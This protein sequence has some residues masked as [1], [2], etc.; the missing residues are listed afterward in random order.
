MAK[1]KCGQLQYNGTPAH[2]KW[3]HASHSA[4]DAINFQDR[5]WTIDA[6]HAGAEFYRSQTASQFG[7]GD[8]SLT[9]KMY[10]NDGNILRTGNDANAVPRKLRARFKITYY[11]TNK[12]RR[13]A[14]R[15]LK[16]LEDWDNENTIGIDQS[17]N[18]RSRHNGKNLKLLTNS[19]DDTNVETVSVPTGMK[20]VNIVRF[21]FENRYP[22]V[23][24]QSTI[25]SDL[26]SDG[27]V[28]D[29]YELQ[30]YYLA[31]DDQDSFGIFN[32]MENHDNP[33]LSG[34]RKIDRD[35]AYPMTLTKALG[36][37]V[38]TCELTWTEDGN[39]NDGVTISGIN[40]LG[41]LIGIEM[42]WADRGGG[43]TL[44]DFNNFELYA[45][46]TCHKWRG[47]GST[48]HYENKPRGGKSGKSKSK[49]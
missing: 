45:E 46:L 24:R 35:W 32:R 12:V 49:K 33:T 14:L 13:D 41:G 40:A 4:F 34:S 15:E 19:L 38:R 48:D 47:L 23:F 44:N 16:V 8:Y 37:Q 28:T 29:D 3:F 1:W 43:G 17:Q 18:R 20:G 42:V 6:T 11:P 9:L 26:N 10:P 39:G 30:H 5:R 31:G 27:D 22:K 36:W 21:G 2:G 7:D 25:T